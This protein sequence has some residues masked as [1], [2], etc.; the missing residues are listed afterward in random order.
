LLIFSRFQANLEP[1][2]NK[3]ERAAIPHDAQVRRISWVVGSVGWHA[4]KKAVPRTACMLAGPHFENAAFAT[5]R[6]VFF[7]HKHQQVNIYV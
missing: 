2:K 1:H 6:G 3:P 4:T 7:S 5:K